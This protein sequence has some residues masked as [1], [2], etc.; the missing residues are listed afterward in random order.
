[1][2][3]LSKPFAFVLALVVGVP[4]TTA[5]AAPK[6]TVAAPKKVAPTKASA[7]PSGSTSS[8]PSATPTAAPPSTARPTSASPLTPRPD[9]APP[10]QAVASARPTVSYDD[11]MAEAAALRARV[12]AVSSVVFTS[13]MKV[14]LRVSTGHAKLSAARLL[15]DG[16]PVWTSPSGFTGAEETVVFDAGL[17]PGTHALTLEIERRDDRDDT[18]RIIDRSTSTVL[19]AQ[20]KRLEIDARVED[21]STMGELP[22]DDEGRWD[23][24]IRLRAKSIAV[25]P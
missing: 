18:F 13:R 16:A 21:D 5:I 8:I 20:G 12:G 9:E 6:S 10:V 1:M 7:A 14:T 22:K 11:L 25:K 23:V 17:A 2:R 19:V 3:S 24:R 15:L 4:A